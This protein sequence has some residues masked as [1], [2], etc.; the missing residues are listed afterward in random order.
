MPSNIAVKFQ[1]KRC[2]DCCKRDWD[3]KLDP[4][5]IADW[6]Q[7]KR[8]DLLYHVVFHPR[9]LMH[10]EYSDYEPILIIDNGHSLFGDYQKHACPFLIMTSNGKASCKI[11]DVKPLVCKEFP[12]APGENGKYYVRTDALDLC[13]GVKDYF[14]SCARTAGE[15]LDDYM[16]KIPKGECEPEHVPI[17]R[18]VVEMLK[19]REESF[20]EEE[21]ATGLLF[22]ELRDKRVASIVFKRFAKIYKRMNLKVRITSQRGMSLLD[23]CVHEDISKI[24]EI[25]DTIRKPAEAIMKEHF[26]RET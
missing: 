10:P 8:G 19:K 2:G 13:R 16:K 26:E 14:E 1:C 24:I 9:F 25:T 22:P 12:F 7:E 5:T 15:S 11:Q 17:P 20:S 6:I 23:A 4:E 21:K 18:D 3:L